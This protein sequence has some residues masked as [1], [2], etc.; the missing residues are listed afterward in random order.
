MDD[1]ELQKIVTSLNRQ[2]EEK[3]YQMS[4]I[5][6]VAETMARGLHEPDYFSRVCTDFI[7]IFD[8]LVCSLFWFRQRQPSGWWLDSWASSENRFQ[9]AKDMVPEADQ[10]LLKWVKEHRKPLFLEN[11]EGE[12][13]NR[14]WAPEPAP[15]T[16][17]TLI[18]LNVDENRIGMFVIIDAL[19]KIST[20]DIQRHLDILSSLINSG[21][22]N[23]SL[24]KG[25]QE[26]EEEFRDLFENSSDMIVV[27]YP[28]GVIRDCN[29][30]F[31]DT[32]RLGFDPHGM[33]LAEVIREEKEHVFA[34]CWS[35]LLKGQEV[36]NEDVYLRLSDGGIIEVELSGN[37]RPLPDG[38][39][40]IIR[41]YLRDLTARRESERK[42]RDLEL[43]LELMRQRQLA[44]VGLYV[45]GIA[46]NLQ[47][48][49]Q[50]L[51][52]YLELLK[53]K[54]V[55]IPELKVIEQSTQSIMDII[56]NLLNKM[57]KE[58]SPETTDINL[59][60]LLDSELTFLNAN[61][62]FK[63]EVT[64]KYH[65][66][67]HL[68]TVRGTYSD[69]SQALMNIIYNALDAMKE[70]EKKELRISTS[71][72]EEKDIISISIADTG[73]GIP[74]EVR[75]SIFQPFFT[76]KEAK[77]CVHNQISSGTGLGLSSSLALLKPY[78]GKISFETEAGKGATFH[79]TLPVKGQERSDG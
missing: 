33:R 43:E 26:S 75:D 50:V 66:A 53:L 9:P 73:C 69:F 11:I 34:D 15:P 57:R 54:G 19:F 29:H 25:L 45:S 38:R 52:G 42:R 41:L 37:V 74:V 21:G 7:Q 14:I 35:E 49:V 70:S 48:P 20:Q 77:R 13:V 30:I 6:M 12:A 23:R 64:K 40:G 71:H 56:E 79:I 47:N 10:G 18:P 55:F 76:T 51:L 62:Y 36:R 78:G 2:L 4:Q 22:R 27:A 8:S 39:L 72:D 5:R 68:P 28:D 3:I 17:M 58:R 32:L 46:H 24:Y 60:E 16:S 31:T 59:N 63:H 1:L 67:E 44:Q 61:H 65:F